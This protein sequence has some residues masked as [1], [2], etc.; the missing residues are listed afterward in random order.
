MNTDAVIESY[1]DDVVRRLPRAHRNDV[2]FELRSLLAEELQGRAAQAG[3]AAD[4]AMTLQLLAAFGRPVDVADRYRPAGFTIIRPADAP[5]FAWVG[6]GGVAV[7][8]ALSLV[9]TYTAPVD[10]AVAEPDWLSR[11]GTWWLSWGLGAFWWPGFIIS[12]TVISGAIR[13]HRQESEEWVPPR[14]RTL[15]RDLVRRPGMVIVLTLTLGVVGASLVLALPMLATWGRALP[16]P[17]LSAFAFDADFLAWRAP[18]VLL[19]WAGS[20]AL[21]VTALVAGRWSRLTRRIALAIDVAW[22]ALLVWW[23]AVGTI[24]VSASSDSVTKGFLAVVAALIMLDVVMLLRRRIAP[25]Q[26]PAV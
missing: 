9:V 18:W 19:L 25:I 1:V 8:W 10:M 2:A 6:L 26:A 13:A 14:T 21:G 16:Q 17:L 22:I 12:L 4:S 23:I 7:Q 5:R 24:F 20:F 3:R 11:L 15:D